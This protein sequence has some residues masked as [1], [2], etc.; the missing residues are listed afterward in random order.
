MKKWLSA[1]LCFMLVGC[2]SGE[3]Q[4]SSTP[5]SFMSDYTELEENLVFREGDHDS[6]EKMLAH[7]TGVIYFSFPECPW[8]QKYTPLLQDIAQEAD[9]EVLYYNIHTDRDEDKDWY[10]QIAGM[11]EEKAPAISRYDNDGNTVIFMPLVLFV[12]E[13]EI[14]GYDDETCDLSSDEIS[15]DTY[16][17]DEKI[18]ALH[19]R[20]LPLF[21][22]VKQAQ[23]EKNEQG[24]AIG[25]DPSC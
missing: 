2:G 11:I 12:N 9:M 25:T 7:G 4:P 6:V 20:V 21:E 8:C 17:T 22:A 5:V 10:D 15:P 18:S 14:I 3:V 23:D 16:W 13:G 19:D 1:L 24:C